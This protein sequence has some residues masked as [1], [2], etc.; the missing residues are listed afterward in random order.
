MIITDEARLK[1]ITNEIIGAAIE[2]HKILGPGLLESVYHG[3]L[4]YELTQKGLFI[5][6]EPSI[7]FS[8]KNSEIGFSLR[9]DMIVEQSVILELKAVTTMLPVFEAQLLSYMKLTGIKV[10]LLINFCVPCLKDGI[11]RK[12]W[13]ETDHPQEHQPRSKQ[14]SESLIL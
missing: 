11:V 8:Y 9:P 3:C 7:P 10:G 1:Q 13:F 6:D 2:V 4:I 12:I 14:I 5:E